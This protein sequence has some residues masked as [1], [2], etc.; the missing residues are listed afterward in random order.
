MTIND[1]EPDRHPA[2][3]TAHSDATPAPG[4][5]PLPVSSGSAPGQ[6]VGGTPANPLE[7]D[8]PAGRLEVLTLME[9]ILFLKRVPLFAHL[10]PAELKQVASITYE[11][12]FDDGELLAEQDEPGDEFFIIVSGEV[13]VLFTD[14]N[15]TIELARRKPGEYV[16]EM[17]IIS[18]APRVARLVAVGEVRALCIGQ[19]QFEV[20]LR[21]RPETSMVVMRVLCDRLRERGNTAH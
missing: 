10:A 19:K 21:E 13:R 14:E 18:R 7:K 9:R 11:N 6:T 4:E 3:H 2:S 12:L 17:A 20:I 1:Q 8:K 16:G 5:D 15:G